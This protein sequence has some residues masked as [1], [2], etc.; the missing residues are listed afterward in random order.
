M[1]EVR[2]LYKTYRS[3]FLRRKVPALRGLS[4]SVKKGEIYGLLGPNGAGKT[5]CLKI[6]TGLLRADKGEVRVLN[7]PPSPYLMKNIGFLPE[8]P[9]LYRHLTGFELLSFFGRLYGITDKRHIEELIDRVGLRDAGDRKV[10]KYS[11]GM[12]QRLG[13]AQAILHDPELIILDEPLS[14][15]DPVGRKEIKDIIL[16]LKE[17]GKTILFSSHILPDVEVVC[18]RVGII[19]GGR[20]L[21]EG[22]LDHIM[23]REIRY[24]E[25]GIRGVKP[26][27][28]DNLEVMR[29][30]E[31]G[32][33]VYVSVRKKEEKN[34][35]L[36]LV[37]ER[38]GEIESVVPH[39]LTLEEYFMEK[40][41]DEKNM[42][43]S[44]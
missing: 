10:G 17:R 6:I 15:L 38:G 7:N 9:F 22:E 4:F 5:T 35:V 28:F 36:K 39:T 13:F 30:I 40:V 16:S 33:V 41:K 42:G 26:S 32:E 2:E 37:M 25:I 1:I 43:N 21:G 44:I 34:R 14:G 20:M 31:R 11:K 19:V 23:E 29:V 8:N 27:V 18:D 12:I 24:Y 3:P